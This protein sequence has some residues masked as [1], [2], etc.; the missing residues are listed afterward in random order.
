MANNKIYVSPGVYTKETDLSYATQSIGVTTLGVVGETLK[1][2]AFEPTLIRN[3]NEFRTRFGLQSPEKF[4]NGVPKY[5]LPYVANT[6]LEQSNQLY[7]TRVLGLSGYDAGKAW[8]ITTVGGIDPATIGVVIT[9]GTT[10]FTGST[11]NFSDST[12]NS[13]VPK[14]DNLPITPISSGSTFTVSSGSTLMYS[15]GSYVGK[16]VSLNILTMSGNTQG[17]AK[18]TLKTITGNTL[19]KYDNI[20][21]ALLRSRGT[22]V[23]NAL[24]FK[25]NTLSINN[26]AEQNALNPFILTSNNNTYTLSFDESKQNFIT[27]VLGTSVN[28]SKNDIFVEDIYVKNLKNLIKEGKVFGISSTLSTQSNLDDYKSQ[29]TTPETPFIVSE[30]R[31]NQI[32][33]LFKFIL[34]SDGN[35]ANKEIK[36]SFENINFDTREFDVVV[37]SFNDTDGLV[38]ILEA[39]RRCTMNPSLNNYIGRRIG[40]T[41]GMY[42]LASQYIMVELDGDAPKDA[43]PSGFE[44]YS[45]KNITGAKPPLMSYKTK[46]DFTKEKIKKAY[47]GI[48]DIT[49]ID[50][51]MFNYLGNNISSGKTLGF[52]MDVNA[53]RNIYSVGNAPFL[54]DAGVMGTDYEKIGARKFTVCPAGG[55]DGWDIYRNVRTN[56]DN[57]RENQAN[58]SNFTLALP[59]DYYAYL[60]GIH[61]F[62]N[63]SD[64]D[65][66]LFATP[67]IDYDR[68]NALVKEAIEMIE[69]DRRDS[70]YII[71][72]PD[73][74]DDISSTEDSVDLLDTADIDSSYAGTYSPWILHNDTQNGVNIYLPPTFEVLRNAAEVDKK[75]APWF[76][77]AGY[78]NGELKSRKAKHKI[79]QDGSNTLYAGRINPIRS[80]SQSPLLIFGNKT[81]Q[82]SDSALNRINVRRL[83]LQVRKLVSVV[84]VRLV[85]EPN[86]STLQDQFK[87]LINPILAD[88]KKQRGVISFDV[89]CDESNN[90]NGDRDQ[91]QL[92]GYIRIK[93]T[94]SAEYIS[95]EYGVT[96]QGA[97]FTDI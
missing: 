46:Y 88:V 2:P 62:N 8:A 16:E 74:P 63:P 50:Q 37:R 11:S 53:N 17:T 45:T 72:S 77:I 28:D 80:Y 27:K 55:F 26:G 59:S 87:R 42:T 94:N 19:T 7:V 41:D 3:A 10:T 39:F 35:A 22:Y 36:I 29:F 43:L 21:V 71:N 6:Y 54:S 31:G 58:F 24:T 96:D 79:S 95:I 40:T 67:G 93:P 12:I 14:F 20:T 52:H 65:I 89:I 51:N 30:L 91:L 57:F 90:S 86:D 25:A 13:L 4:A 48:S 73:Q 23:N 49:G 68:Q 82:I 18:Y 75:R 85:F 44:G 9:T 61:T 97:E 56:T 38:S 83:L 33:R 32:E 92:N 84:A 1:G 70:F 76:A 66:N 81:L 34:I 5:E 69:E 15:N 64:I 78:T 60:K 47:L